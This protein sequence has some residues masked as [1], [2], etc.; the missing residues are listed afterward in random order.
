MPIKPIA[1]WTLSDA[2]TA[3]RSSLPTDYEVNRK[4]IEDGDHFQDGTLWPGGRTGDAATDAAILKNVEPQFIADDVSG[5]MVENRTNGLLGQEADVDLVPLVALADSE[6]TDA[7]DAKIEAILGE[8][9][10]WWDRKGF[11]GKAGEAI[12]RVS[13]A[14]RASLR[15]YVAAGNLVNGALPKFGTLAEALNAIEI[16]APPT[17][18]AI[19][20][21]D[22][23]TQRPAAVIVTTVDDKDQA[24]IWTLD[25][26]TKQTS[27]RVIGSTDPVVPLDLKGRLPL[28]EMRGARIITP[29]VRKIQSLLNFITT[30]IG[31]TV[32]TASARER[33]FTNVEPPG[34][35]LP[36]APTSG[37]PLAVDTT[38]VP[39]RTYY[40]HRV[41]W[42]VGANVSNELVGFRTLDANGREVFATPGVTVL[43]PV[44]P[45]FATNAA[46]TVTLRLY[47]RGK[48]GHL[49]L[50]D[51]AQA[52]GTAYQQARAQFEAD[53]KTLKG[54][55]EGMVRDA[56][57]AVLAYAGL[58]YP[59][60]AGI[61]DRY[62][63]AV[64]MHVTAGPVTADEARLAVELRDKGAIAQQTMQ[65][66][67][68]I[69]DPVAE[70]ATIDAEPAAQLAL[71]KA[72]LEVMGIAITSAQL[73]QGVAARLAGFT[74]EQLALILA[75]GTDVGADPALPAA[76]IPA[77]FATAA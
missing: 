24:E 33:Y 56:L 31:R 59:A 4:L 67:V 9:S 1:D 18:L 40:K 15:V 48:Q 17:H 69:E 27:V 26:A 20:Y 29:S 55:A 47:K 3:A 64:T 32:E 74:E 5:E 30:G 6:T 34:M 2:Q 39:G 70:Q 57:E 63:V 54:P 23:K 12:G 76:N 13:Y 68:G 25:P 77:P 37:P 19:R 35:W 38:T 21:V 73:P 36:T 7:Q 66:R 46:E 61:L 58:M 28:A 75:V 44:D 45:A 43:D 8:L 52:S 42:V 51:S 65:A 22:P 62:R 10:A 60:A 11:W 49:G 41:P 14:K 71:V 16:D 50:A 72:R 53:L